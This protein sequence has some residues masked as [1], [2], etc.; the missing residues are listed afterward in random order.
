MTR[1]RRKIFLVNKSLQV[2]YMA[3]VAIMMIAIS[4]ITGWAIYAT[5][6]MT[7]LDRC[8]N[9]IAMIDKIFLDLNNLLFIR[10]SLL[11][12]SGV[13][14]GVIIIM[15]MVH[16]IAGPLYRVKKVLGVIGDGIIPGEVRFR[17]KDELKYIADGINK[18]TGKISELQEKNLNTIE[19]AKTC[20]KRAEE[21]MKNSPPQTDRATKEIA[22]ALKSLTDIQ[23]FKKQE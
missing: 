20:L 22:S 13:C 9:Q 1:R 2:R 4:I 21:C 17:H 6:W 12:L 7:L 10:I 16:R 19:K 8:N 23:T 3:M 11:I 14:I 15:F 5:T 18:V